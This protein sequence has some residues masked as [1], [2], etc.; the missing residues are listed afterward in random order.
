MKIDGKQITQ[1]I[2][3]NL[4]KQVKKLREKNIY[5]KLAIIMV[6]NDPASIAYIRQKELKAEN[7]GMKTATYNL[8]PTIQ[9]S[10]LIKFIEK[11]NNDKNI[12]GIIVQQPLPKSINVKIITQAIDPK[13][14]VDGFHPDSYFQMPIVMAILK[15]LEKVYTSNPKI[16]FRFVDW[17]KS[18]KI[19]VIGKGETGGKPIIQM[20]KKM[21]IPVLVIDSK[22]KRPENMTKKADIIIS[23][24]GK[25]NILKPEMIKKGVILISIGI[26][27]EKN[28]K[29]VGDY[30]ENEIKDIA[31]FYTSTPGGIGPVNVAM[32]LKNLILACKKSFQKNEA[33]QKN[34]V[35]NGQTLC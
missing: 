22:T 27:R 7:I 14:D 5:P 23:A 10:E 29:L 13:K 34:A 35:D 18:N 3:G 1:D 24:V 8:K 11:L 15:I 12:H 6:T 26:S 4:Q 33:F 20:F 21:K 31:S 17:L 2:L 30:S 9:N 32:L 25:K 16:Q 28:A 19:A